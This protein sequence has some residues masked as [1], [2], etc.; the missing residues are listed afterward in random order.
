MSGAQTTTLDGSDVKV[1]SGGVTLGAILENPAKFKGTR[2]RVRARIVKYLAGIMNKNW[3]HLKDST[4]GEADVVGTT[5][6][7]FKTGDTVVL[8]ATV[9]TDRDFGFGYRYDVLL[10]QVN[11]INP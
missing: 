4:T 3:I 2:V 1:L 6:E 11:R 9:T 10:E 8:E 5:D 7:S